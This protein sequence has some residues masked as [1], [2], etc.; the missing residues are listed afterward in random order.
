PCDST[1]ILKACWRSCAFSEGTTV[2]SIRLACSRTSSGT[3]VGL[4]HFEPSSD[5]VVSSDSSSSELA[6]RV[7]SSLA[8]VWS[9]VSE[10]ELSESGFSVFSASRFGSRRIWMAFASSLLL[11]EVIFLLLWQRHVRAAQ[12]G[13]ALMQSVCE[14]KM[15]RRIV[16][17]KN[18]RSADHQQLEMSL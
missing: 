10:S 13:D 16:R 8:L 17:R 4:C 5:S 7:F 11:C 2:N 15:R 12:I 18:C 14:S 6:L 1:R 9:A 3:S